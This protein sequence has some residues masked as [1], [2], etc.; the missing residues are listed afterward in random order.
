MYALP[1]LRLLCAGTMLIG[2]AN[3]ADLPG[4]KDPPGFK[5][6]EGSEIIHYET[7]SYGQYFMARGEGSIGV[8]FEKEERA[9]G[10]ITRVIYRAPPGTSS[11]EVFRN[12]EQMLE[13]L[14]FEPTYKLDSGALYALSAKD[15]H[16]RFYF[17]AQYA[18]RKD[19]EATPFQ[20]S[21]NQYYLTARRMR[22]G[23]TINVA[24]HVAESPGLSWPEPSLK[25]PIEIK[26][27]QAL[28]G[29]DIIASKQIVYRMVEVKAEQIAKA[30]VN[31]GKI[32]IYGIYFDI[33]KTDLKPESKAALDEMAK[34]IKS[35][36]TL[37]V[38]VAGHTDNTGT[39]AYNLEL[40]RGR[41]GAVVNELI[42]AY[43]V[44]PSQL[45]PQG[46]GDTRPVAPNDTDQARAKN[47]RVELRRL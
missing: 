42:S 29:I 20:D 12:Y 7:L 40:S 31:P 25:Q 17:Q 3:A 34:L 6:F 41:A 9:E 26:P 14:G 24:V 46:Y 38:E 19:H 2:V 33:D 23:Q 44:D 16:Q 27:S 32:D 5:R 43:G 1:V 39:P 22:D 8:G 45:Q 37:R 10:A 30:L 11:L 4:S 36:P 35:D 18:A 15:F 28:I 13:D 21:K 47:R